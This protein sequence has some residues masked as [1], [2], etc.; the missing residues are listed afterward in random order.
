MKKTNILI[1]NRLKKYCGTD[2]DCVNKFLVSTFIY[3]HSFRRLNKFL[4]EYLITPINSKYENFE[5]FK[6]E[7]TQK[8]ISANDFGLE[9][10]I[11]IFEFVIS[12]EDKVVT[13][14]VYTPKYIR[15]FIT[16]ETLKSYKS[17]DLYNIKIIDLA[18]GCG[19]FLINAALYINKKTKKSF[20]KIFE[21]NLYGID[22]ANYS[23][24]RTKILFN[25]I[26]AQNDEIEDI[27]KYNL[28]HGNSLNP[29]FLKEVKIK[30]NTENFDVVLG[31]PPY[32]CARNIPEESKK[33]LKYWKVCSTGLPDLYIPFFQIGIENLKNTGKLGYITMNT[34]F[35]SLNATALRKYFEDNKFFLRIIDFGA[36]QVFKQKSTYT[37]LAFVDKSVNSHIEYASVKPGEIGKKQIKYKKIFYDNLDY[38]EGWN[39]QD[40]YWTTK[41]ENTGFP[42]KKLYRISSGIATLRDKIYIIKPIFEDEEYFYLESGEKVEKAICKKVIN[43]NKLTKKVEPKK[44]I[45]PIIFPYKFNKDGKPILIEED[46]F[47][48]NYPYAYQYLSKYKE[49]LLKRDKGKATNYPAWYAYGRTQ[50]LEKV[51]YKMLFPHLVKDIPYFYISDDEN[52]YSVNGMMA[53]SNSNSLEDLKLLKAIMSSSV[54]WEYI[55]KTSKRYSSGYYSLGFR[56]LKNFGIPELSKDDKSLLTK[57]DNIDLVNK[58]LSKYYHN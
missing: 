22:I 11:E 27:K 3:L 37:C 13:G 51:K 21:E 17:E 36:E 29:E 16:K 31:N 12:P 24:E 48:E 18:C 15:E 30:S 40:I 19:G 25:L 20:V 8:G 1:L 47:L 28:Y 9:D 55:K 41:I 38:K 33:L 14:A 56:Y 4:T 10:L 52:L 6:Q 45:Y 53:I 39:L 5:K 32:V 34:F 58:I 50:N 43:S 2:V 35:K 46:E 26:A 54:F 23:V 44:F 57:T 42:L 7:I 49:E